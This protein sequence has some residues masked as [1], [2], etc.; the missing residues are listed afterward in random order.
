MTDLVWFL[1]LTSF[2]VYV[3][4]FFV[5]PRRPNW[6]DYKKRMADKLRKEM[7]AYVKSLKDPDDFI[8]MA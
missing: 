8:G 3:M 2:I 1:F 4:S 5:K 7:D 6:R